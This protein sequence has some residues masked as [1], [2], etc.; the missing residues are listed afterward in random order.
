MPWLRRLV[1]RA[2]AQTVSLRPVTPEAWV[3][4]YNSSCGFC[5]G[6]SVTGTGSPPPPPR[7]SFYSFIIIPPLLHSYSRNIFRTR[8]TSGRSQGNLKKKCSFRYRATLDKTFLS[9]YFSAY[10]LLDVSVFAN[11]IGCISQ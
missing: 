1:F 2:L 8:R 5:G 10:F 7:L 11:I 3:R 4:S 6:Q 9:R